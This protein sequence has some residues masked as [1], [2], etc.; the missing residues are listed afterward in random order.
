MYLATLFVTL[1][2]EPEVPNVDREKVLRS[3]RDKLRQIYTHRITIRTDDESAVFVSLFDD[4]FERA[5][6]RLEEVLEKIESTGHA[7]IYDHH[8]QIFAWHE[9]QFV[10]TRENL[11][12]NDTASGVDG[13][14][15]AAGASSSR[16]IVYTDDEDEFSTM[17][18]R[19][20]RR[21]LRIP[22]RK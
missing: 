4:G 7:R 11:D 21:S 6:N 19:L 10:E 15:V 13:K 17:P 16:T 5:K 18:S 3:L 20:Q 8:A 1:D 2:L 12:I 14:N 9:G 22:T